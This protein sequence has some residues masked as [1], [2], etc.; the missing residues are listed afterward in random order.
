MPFELHPDIP[1]EGFELETNPFGYTD[2]FEEYVERLAKKSGL[3]LN[4]PDFVPNTRLALQTTL[5]EKGRGGRV[6]EMVHAIF[7]AYFVKGRNI[8]DPDMLVDA[9]AEARLET[10]APL[11][12]TE[13]PEYGL[14]LDRQIERALEMGIVVTPAAQICDRLLKGAKPYE[15][16]EQAVE[17]CLKRAA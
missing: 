8:G 2:H 14:E 9:L 17:E 16:F 15:I 1:P 13:N 12:A 10:A 7:R 5:Y 6:D 4:M 11:A 3:E